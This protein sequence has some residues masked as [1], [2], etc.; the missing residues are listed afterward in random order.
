MQTVIYTPNLFC[1]GGRPQ[2]QY[3]YIVSASPDRDHDVSLNV[4]HF[5][6]SYNEKGSV[7]SAKFNWKLLYSTNASH[8]NVALVDRDRFAIFFTGPDEFEY[9]NVNIR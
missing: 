7:E 6:V 2:N 3:R 9:M 8:W 5:V 4:I 1:V